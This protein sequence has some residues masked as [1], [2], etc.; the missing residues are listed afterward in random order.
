M[1]QS[2]GNKIRDNYSYEELI[3]GAVNKAVWIIEDNGLALTGITKL[4]SAFINKYPDAKNL[5]IMDSMTGHII[6]IKCSNKEIPEIANYIYC[7]EKG[8]PLKLIPHS[9]IDNTYIIQMTI[10]RGN[11]EFADYE[12]KDGK[13]V[14]VTDYDKYF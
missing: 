6:R 9:K 11:I 3:D 2:L 8:T 5:L 13:L 4:V 1:I 10:S 7:T 14:K 12:S